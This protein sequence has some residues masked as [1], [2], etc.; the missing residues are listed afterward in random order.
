MTIRILY[1]IIIFVFVLQPLASAQSQELN[2]N[3][4]EII[5]EAVKN[6]VRARQEN[7]NETL[8]LEFIELEKRYNVPNSLSGMLLAS[9]CYESGFNPEAKGDYYLNN[10]GRRVPRAIGIF[11]MWPWWEN[12]NGYSINRRNPLEAANAYIRHIVS[13]ISKVRRI[14]RYRTPR[15]LWIA[16]WVTA[17]RSY[18][19]EGRC[20]E[21]PKHLR[22]LRRWH[23]NIKRNRN[24][25]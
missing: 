17:I 23:M 9:A 15:R 22:L 7:I 14:C 2:I 6:C 24:N 25:G 1:Q 20:H 13:K 16:A 5:S 12:P 18:K 3:Y 10:K 8:F 11:Q 4:D 19:P 21:R